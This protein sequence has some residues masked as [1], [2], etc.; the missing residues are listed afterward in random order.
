[1]Y[2][3]IALLHSIKCSF[4]Y[5]PGNV[6]YSRKQKLIVV[7]PSKCVTPQLSW[8]FNKMWSNKRVLDYNPNDAS[9][10]QL[11]KNLLSTTNQVCSR[12][13]TL[14]KN[15]MPFLRSLNCSYFSTPSFKC[16][17]CS[18]SATFNPS[19]TFIL[20][21]SGTRLHPTLFLLYLWSLCKLISL[22]I[23]SFSIFWNGRKEEERKKRRKGREGLGEEKREGE[24]ED[25]NINWNKTSLDFP[26]L[27]NY[28]LVSFVYFQISWRA[29][30]KSW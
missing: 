17:L 9:S 14:E 30:G 1:M 28:S 15:S 19:R 26:C 21:Y 13:E 12:T 18:I 27:S 22:S 7:S 16:K 25:V 11:L 24:K 3:S 2:P 6:W 4:K 29:Q 23:K 8:F 20:V 10:L 5:V